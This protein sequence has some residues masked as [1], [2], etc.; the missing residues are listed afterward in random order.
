[1]RTLST[2]SP[3]LILPPSSSHLPLPAQANG[4]STSS[5]SITG[6]T[7]AM[8]HAPPAGL[9]RPRARLRPPK[10]QQAP[11]DLLP[12]HAFL[13]IF[14]HLPTNQ[15]CRC[16]RVC[17]RWYNLAWDPRLWRSIRLTGDLLH[18]DRAL[19]VLTRRLCQD[20]P[21]VCLMLEAVAASGCRRL[22][23]RGLHTVAQ[24]CPELRRLEVAGCYNVSNMAVF[25]VVSRCPNLEHLDVSGCS[26]VTCISLTRDVSLKLL[27]VHGQQISIRYL[28]MTDC[29]A[30][31]D[32]GLHTIAAHCTQLTHLYLRRCI[33]LTDEGLRYLVIYCPS[34][35][36]L[37][38]SDCRFVSDFGLREIA[39][40]EGRLRY[41][42]VA[43]CGR[44]TD[45]RGLEHLAKNC[46]KLKSLDIGKCPL[47][48]DAGLELLALNCFNLKRL[49]L[50]SCESITGR[51][52]QVVAANCFDLQL[53]N[54][55]DCDVPQEALR[56]VKRHC[57]RCVIEHTNPAFF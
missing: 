55:Q 20:T 53:L 44:I 13:Q 45:T 4:S 10:D 2:P 48:S 23:D 36:E 56:F 27:P 43:H 46:P 32:E 18:A 33:R 24:C 38:V 31:E 22:T 17:R 42:S 28:D 6:E 34:V 37:S 1:M 3:A 11:V 50:K 16:A 57:K 47:V 21:N 26:K 25:E 54:V 40:L 39:K 8:V 29:F 30:L 5:S 41:L 12:D 9:I 15:L 35:R 7:V 52:L 49:S 51:G 14:A 19:R